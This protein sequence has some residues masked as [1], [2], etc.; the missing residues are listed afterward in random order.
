MAITADR[1]VVE[2]E[3]RLGR[4]EANVA[5]AEGK[6]DK[7]MGNIQRSAGRA[8]AVV[9]RA[10]GGIGA[11]LAGVSAVA[12]AR[13]F[14]QIADE[15][16][17]LDAQLKLATAGF[18][19][20]GKAQEDV[21]RIAEVTRS[22]LSA[23]AQLYGNFSRGAK[24]LGADQAA[25]ARATETFSKTLKIS[26]ADA[27][28]AASA[29]LQF[30]QA[31][32]AGALRGDELNSVL[33]ASPRLARLLTESMGRSIGEIKQLGE[34]GKLTADVLL[35]ALTNQKFTAGIDAEFRE[36]PVTFDDAMTQVSNAAIITFGAFDRGGEFSTMLANFVTDG[37]DGFKDMEDAALQFGINAR[38]SI[39][40]LVG[41]FEPIFNEAKEFFDFL[42]VS[43][44]D[45]KFD[46]AQELG[47][48][49]RITAALTKSIKFRTSSG[50]FGPELK[51]Y[52]TDSGT[53]FRGRYVA[54]RDA[55][56]RRRQREIGEQDFRDSLRGF[57]SFGRSLT[58]PRSAA[59]PSAGGKK[60]G[61]S[62]RTPR[63]PLDADAFAREEA[64]LNDQILRLK[65]DEVVDAS[66]RA[67][68]E[69]KRME[70]AKTAAATDVQNDKRFTAAQKEKLIA[71]LGTV[72]ALTQARI[73]AERDAQVAQDNLREKIASIDNDRDLLRAQA[74]LTDGRRERTAIELRLVDLAYEQERAE[75]EATIASKEASEAQKRVARQRL[76]I[77]GQLQAGEREGVN[78]RGESPLARYRRDLNNPDRAGDE[79]EAAVI[80][81]LESV[82]DGISNAVQKA[83]G[84]KNPILAALLNAFIEQQLIKPFVDGL[85]NVQGGGGGLVGGILN[86]GRSLFGFAGGG[87]GIVG[88]RGGTDRNTLS[89]NGV[90]FANVSRGE[91]LYVG[92]KALA[93]RSSSG[94]TVQ[95]TIMVD[96]RGAVMND[97]FARM[98]LARADEN[99][100]KAAAQVGQ[101]VIKSVPARMAQ[102]QTDGT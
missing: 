93:G 59:R 33:E 64:Q 5:R 18:G 17:N 1:V 91:P 27:N 87:R 42:N 80:D 10:M 68:A 30:G 92:S 41:A 82:R 31:L 63:A 70:A 84:V 20:F 88:G 66:A 100:Q 7:A 94:S 6:F 79:V 24:E 36:L 46:M 72:N 19:S 67:L 13:T 95:Q 23:T 89:L 39:E 86:V 83:L 73:L 14:L 32:A 9:S 76:D 15:A 58:T 38:A 34:E 49:D 81:E 28:Q 2:M 37:T 3:A 21:R 43:L 75:L 52:T 56:A 78:R 53:N 102:F 99:A 57:D 40:G 77:L 74:E 54:A 85:A 4:Y 65:E 8:E 12:L 16:K 50:P 69:M 29:T 71:L 90:P 60:T 96:A 25:A 101:R 22:G 48:L 98:I 61:G 26:G 62:K 55:A 47:D 44:S 45:F 11:A 97:Q 51:F 35:N